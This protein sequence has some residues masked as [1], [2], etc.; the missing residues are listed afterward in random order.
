MVVEQHL[1]VPRATTRASTIAPL[2]SSEATNDTSRPCAAVISTR[3][4]SRTGDAS[5][6]TLTS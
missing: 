2:P 3:N 4:N 6:S 1:A 5:R